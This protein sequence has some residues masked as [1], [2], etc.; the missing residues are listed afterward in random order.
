ML[1]LPADLA[2]AE[3]CKGKLE[4]AIVSFENCF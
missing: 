4:K 1:K 3:E 2:K